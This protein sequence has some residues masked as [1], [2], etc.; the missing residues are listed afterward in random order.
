MVLAAG[1]ALIGCVLFTDPVNSPPRVD[2]I[3]F[4]TTGVMRGR[5]ISVEAAVSDPD[6]DPLAYQ[7]SS[8]VGPCADPVDRTLRPPTE[9]TTPTYKITVGVQQKNSVRCVWLLVTDSH[10]ASA[11]DAQTLT[12][13]N[14]APVAVIDIQQPIRNPQGRFDLFSSFRLSGAGSHDDDGDNLLPFSWKLIA[15]DPAT[16]VR[17]APCAPTP[18]ADRVQCFSPGAHPGTYT[19]EL[20]VND[21]IVDSSPEQKVLTVDPD[22]PPCVTLTSPPYG[23]G[24]FVD[25]PAQPGLFSILNVSDDGDPFPAAATPP[26]GSARFVWKIRHAGG[27]W[28]VIPGFESLPTLT[29]AANTFF[30]GNLIDVRAEV[31]DRVADHTL[32]AC[33]D[34]DIC[35]VSCPQRVTWTVEYR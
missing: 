6:H 14:N 21:G 27:D 29:I 33:G 25:D 16:D 5:T 4:P 24:P 10:G 9:Q 23:A 19:V 34:D 15:P 26:R 18:P 12:P 20:V 11:V 30:S 28:R 8:A 2:K 7:W 17:L 22:S 32:G 35:P 13:I 1:S 3:L 31:I